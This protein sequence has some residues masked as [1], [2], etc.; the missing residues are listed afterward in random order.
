MLND[1]MVLTTINAPRHTALPGDGLEFSLRNPSVDTVD[2]MALQAFFYECDLGAQLGFLQG[3]NI[4]VEVALS[5]LDSIVR[6]GFPKGYR[7]PL[8]SWSAA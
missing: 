8:D 7:F 1:W 3:R 5:A 4:P 2:T 6:P